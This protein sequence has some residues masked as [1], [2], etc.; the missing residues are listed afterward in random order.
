MRNTRLIT[1][2]S[3]I[4][5][6]SILIV[7]CNKKNQTMPQSNNYKT[8]TI[9]TSNQTVYS[10]YSAT[11]KGKQDVDIYP[12]VSGTITK[13]CFKEGDRVRKGQT[14][15]IIDPAPY[16][17]A[18][19]TAQANV[20]NAKTSV[21]TAQMT[22]ESKEALYK[23]NVISAFDLQSAKNTLA[24]QKALLAQA[25]AELSN[26]R[27]NLS[28]TAVKSPVNGVAG[29]IA[30]RQ[31]ALV[32]SSISQPLVSVSNNSKICA[33]F[34]LTENEILSLQKRIGTQSNTLKAMPE[35][36]LR[37]SDGT[38][39]TKSGKI[40]A[41]SGIVDSKT[42]SISVRASFENSQHLLRSGSS[43]N[44]IMPFER[45]NCISVRQEATYELQDKIFVYKVVN[46]KTQSQE[47]TVFSVNDGKNYIVESGLQEG[48]VIIASGAGLLH[49]GISVG[50]TQSKGG[51]K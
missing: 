15:F 13:I 38:E 14:L 22:L 36:R 5:F 16:R 39:Y 25:Q 9:S 18:L 7:A 11:L 48:D 32:N 27:N 34:S 21:A 10:N 29:M 46:G 42:G 49:D 45:Q 44:V 17:A 28:Y 6:A 51:R 41:I 37:L 20:T 30:Y 31:G 35:V 26:A 19:A 33:Y 2:V 8:L 50:T 47:I 4:L 3:V 43:A 1:N 24:S 40:D 12:Q 23:S